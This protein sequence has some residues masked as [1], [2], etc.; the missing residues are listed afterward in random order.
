V[1]NALAYRDM[2]TITAALSFK[3]KATRGFDNK[4]TKKTFL[5]FFRIFFC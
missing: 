1:A 3:A 5:K 2:A 4:I